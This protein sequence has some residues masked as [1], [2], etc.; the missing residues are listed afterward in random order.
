VEPKPVPETALVVFASA[1]QLAL[2]TQPLMVKET[3]IERMPMGARMLA[4]ED[5]AQ[6]RAKIGQL[7]SWL[8]VQLGADGKQGF[9]AAWYVTLALE[10]VPAVP[11]PPEEPPQ[12]VNTGLIVYATG[13]GLAIAL[14][15]WFA[16]RDQA[17][18]Q[19]QFAALA[20]TTWSRGG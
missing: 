16:G 9:V 10:D 20:L 1:D 15:R 2:R 6:A 13:D 12:P 5:A 14:S 11:P 8:E 7:N 17:V 3:L 19:T 18:P 4:L